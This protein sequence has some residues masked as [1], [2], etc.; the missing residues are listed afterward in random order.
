MKLLSA[1]RHL[2]LGLA[3]LAGQTHSFP[4]SENLGRLARLD[5]RTPEQL[6]EKLLQLKQ[7]GLLSDSLAAPI[8]GKYLHLRMDVS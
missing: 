1:S 8:Q 7:K 6:H 3:A 5:A 4:T 2:A